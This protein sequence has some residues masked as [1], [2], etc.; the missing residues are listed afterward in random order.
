MCSR[1]K[2]LLSM[3]L[4]LTLV[5]SLIAPTVVAAATSS[6]NRISLEKGE[7]ITLKAT[8]SI[9]YRTWWKSSN[10]KVAS[11]SGSG[12][13]T[14]KGEGTATI[15][16]TCE[17]KLKLINI[18]GIF[19]SDIMTTYYTVVVTD[20]DAEVPTEPQP[21]EPRPTEPE[22]TEPEPTEPRPTEPRPTEP[23]PTEP[24]PTEPQPTEPRPTEP[25]PTEPRPTEPQPIEP[26]PTEPRPT[27]PQPTE[28]RP[29]EPEPTEPQPTEPQPTEPEPTEPE[30]TEPEPTEPEP[31]EPE[32]TEP[33]E[34]VVDITETLDAFMWKNAATLRRVRSKYG[35]LYAAIYYYEKV[36]DGGDWDIKQQEEWHF[37]QGTTY[38]YQ[39]QVLR[40]DDPGN[41]HFGYVGAVIFPEE[42]VCFGAGMNNVSK[43]GF[44]EG[45]FDSYYDDPQDQ[46]MMRWGYRLYV[47]GY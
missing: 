37:E 17:N 27:E 42:F 16:A 40:M 1:T 36:K 13:V 38:V 32:P 10:S 25:Q 45:D 43:F 21:T 3:M 46:A 23:Q 44:S 7:R 2:R 47:S 15:T 20:P 11:V 28:P 8:S 29:T 9:L 31:T 22:P 30:P 18:F 26:Q 41:I 4:A 6:G 24:R 34:T 5:F 33:E 19:G 39:G 35:S 12:V 14:A